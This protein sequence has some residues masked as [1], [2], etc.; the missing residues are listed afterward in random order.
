MSDEGKSRICLGAVAGAF[1]VRGEVR[2]KPF[3]SAPEDVAAYGPVETEDR[4]R[5]FEIRVTGAI[6]GGLAARLSG[7]SS[8]EEAEA[9]KGARFYVDRSALP[10]PGEEEEYY[11][12]DL[13]GLLVEDLRGEEIGRVVAV[14]DFGA[15][16]V[17]EI[18]R[19]GAKN[20]FLPFTR[21]MAPHV[22]LAGG[23][24]VADPPEGLFDDA[25][26]KAPPEEA[27]G[28]A[29]PEGGGDAGAEP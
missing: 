1:G 22:D 17:L 12:A 28:E 7:V 9:L 3:T 2:I 18:R 4:S 20:A 8:R 13:I 23:L 10:D 5:R 25:D 16:D 11:H 15:G 24:I 21:E 19:S 14:W 27:G 29:P 6:K 26:D